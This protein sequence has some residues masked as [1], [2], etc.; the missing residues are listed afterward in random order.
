MV[1]LARQLGLGEDEVPAAT[2]RKKP[3]VMARLKREKELGE[4]SGD[5]DRKLPLADESG[6]KREKT[7][8]D[9]K[10]TAEKTAEP[11]GH[12]SDDL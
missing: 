1:K 7:V 8:D 4:E 9:G 2:A 5:D 10:K 12:T 6:A 11:E 3:I